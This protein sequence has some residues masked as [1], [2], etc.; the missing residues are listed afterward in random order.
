MRAL[1]LVYRW[2][3]FEWF[4]QAQEQR[5]EKGRGSSPGRAKSALL[6]KLRLSFG[7]ADLHVATELFHVPGDWRAIEA[8][9]RAQRAAAAAAQARANESDA[10]LQRDQRAAARPRVQFVLDGEP[11]T[12]ADTD[13]LER[14]CRSRRAAAAAA[15]A[16]A[17]E[18]ERTLV[19]ALR[20][21]R[22]TP[23]Q[24]GQAL[25]IPA[26]RV[27]ATLERTALEGFT[28]IYEASATDPT[29]S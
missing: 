19:L 22:L 2:S 14:Q 12:T 7:H 21:F 27:S 23:L 11:A 24:I 18:L 25:S 28:P 9:W 13:E 4:V 5:G 1:N 3:R 6:R 17:E 15:L 20:R 10:F 8:E 29:A 26:S 16:H